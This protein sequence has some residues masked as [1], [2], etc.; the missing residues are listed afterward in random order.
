MSKQML[1][2]TILNELSGTDSK[3]LVASIQC[4][5]EAL[6]E[7]T[8]PEPYELLLI[9]NIYKFLEN[10]QLLK[11]SLRLYAKILNGKMPGEVIQ[12]LQEKRRTTWDF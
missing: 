2:Q 1:L 10:Y 4:L 11:D 5:C 3:D 7:K 8:D 9:D 12:R 6:E